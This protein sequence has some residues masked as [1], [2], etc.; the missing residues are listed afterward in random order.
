MSTPHSPGWRRGRRTRPYPCTK[1]GSDG[2]LCYYT[3]PF[4]DDAAKSAV[5]GTLLVS[6]EAASVSCITTSG[7]ASQPLAAEFGDEASH[8]MGAPRRARGD[9]PRR[10]VGAGAGE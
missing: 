3:E 10:G 9:V 8:E 2:G 6:D 7:M 4:L 5:G 1:L